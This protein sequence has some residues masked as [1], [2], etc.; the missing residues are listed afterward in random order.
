V[1]DGD[2]REAA[3]VEAKLEVA[4]R[5]SGPIRSRCNAAALIE[6][7]AGRFETMR[8]CVLGAAPHAAAK[9]PR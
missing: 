5:A 1:A 3:Q 7:R 8:E 9:A 6:N 2:D 4:L